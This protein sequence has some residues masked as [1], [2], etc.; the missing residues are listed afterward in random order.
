MD[1]KTFTISINAPREKVWSTLWED[2]TYRK[3]T[4]AFAEGSWA[5]TDWKKGSKAL[6][7][8]GKND[9]MVSTIA[10]NKP[11]EFMSIK[12]LGIVKNGVE[13]TTKS[14]EWSGAL[15]NYTLK[16]VNGK[17]ELVIDFGIKDI[18]QEMLSYFMETW[19][20][21]LAKLKELAEKN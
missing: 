6:F 18:P 3:W 12:H 5:K 15:E 21:A 8:D 16:P 2:A 13:D 4:A 14:G 17:T 11:N 10:D 9:G 20:K 7:L 19:P 1:T